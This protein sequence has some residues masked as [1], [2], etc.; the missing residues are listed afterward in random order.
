MMSIVGRAGVFII[1]ECSQLIDPINQP[2]FS[3]VSSLR[4]TVSSH[5]LTPP[6]YF[7]FTSSLPLVVNLSKNS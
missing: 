1:I 2:A 5:G 3:V 6:F 7:F 4:E